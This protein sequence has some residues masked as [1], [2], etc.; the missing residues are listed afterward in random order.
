[1]TTLRDN[2]LIQRDAI[3]RDELQLL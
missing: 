1:M 3:D 2:V